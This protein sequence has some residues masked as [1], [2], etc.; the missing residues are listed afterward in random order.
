[1]IINVVT[2]TVTQLRK[3]LLQILSIKPKSL[4]IVLQILL[5]KVIADIV[6]NI[7]TKSL[8][9]YNNYCYKCM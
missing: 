8:Q 9:N 5:H 1:M 7:I 3:I 2:N 6:A 4:Q